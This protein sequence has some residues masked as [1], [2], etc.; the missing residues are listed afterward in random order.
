MRK[1][2]ITGGGLN[3]KGAQA[4]LF[5]CVDELSRRF[6]NHSIVVVSDN[7]YEVYKNKK[8]IY[9]FEL[10]KQ[11]NYI[12]AFY[13]LG[14]LYRF[15]ARI[16]GIDNNNIEKIDRFFSEVDLLIDISGYAL[17]SCWSDDYNL[18]FLSNLMFSKVYH[19]SSYLMPQSFGPFDYKGWKGRIIKILSKRFL[20]V[21][22]TIY[23]RENQGYELLNKT[24]H[25]KNTV[26]SADMVLKNK[27]IDLKNVF[28][29]ERA[30]SISIEISDK[31]VCIIPNVQNFRYLDKSKITEMYQMIINHLLE[32]NYSIYFLRHSAEDLDLCNSIKSLFSDDDHVIIISED[33]DCIQINSILKKFKFIIASRYHSIVHA[34]KNYVP[35]LAIGWSEKYCSLLEL[36]HQ[37]DYLIDIRETID[38]VKLIN[39]LSLLEK[40][41]E[42]EKK[43][44]MEE[45]KVLQTDNIFD[46]IK[47]CE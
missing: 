45:V 41:Y 25:L 8:N 38:P 31:A 42:I 15:F 21:S 4:M 22:N 20:P 39:K 28:L 16:K 47:I 23:A 29:V 33:F 18:L 13:K 35:C 9:N 12:F 44:I 24:Y 43:I 46:S 34:F 14:G 1:I 30:E 7:D 27:S 19:F 3:N 37:K 11:I 6:P 17:A 2:L 36:V 5:I 40:K 26:L 32:Q 10:I